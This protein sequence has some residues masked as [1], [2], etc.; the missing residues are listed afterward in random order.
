VIDELAELLTLLG[1]HR[2]VMHEFQSDR[3]G[4]VIVAAIRE[5]R[6]CADVVVL[7]DEQRASAWR[8]PRGDGLDVLAPAQVLW[9]YAANPLWTLRALLT[10]PPPGHPDAPTDAIVA[11]V[12]LGLPIQDRRPVRIRMRQHTEN[13][14]PDR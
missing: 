3:D 9:I 12:G 1:K 10:L 4:P 6:A 11:P 5:F 14:A 2:F 13:G 8:T 7:V